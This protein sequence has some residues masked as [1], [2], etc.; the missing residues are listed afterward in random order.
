MVITNS[1]DIAN[2]LDCQA[3]VSVVLS[4]GEWDPLARYLSGE[5]AVETIAAYR[6]DWVFLGTCALHPQAGM[7][8]THCEDATLKRT[9][10]R[11]GMKAVLLTDHG[12]FDQVAPHFVAPLSAL[13]VV[14]TDV[15]A[16]WLGKTGVRVIL[17]GG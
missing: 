15:A 14:V 8:A 6:A 5:H 17:A 4:G 12:K 1:L 11:S 3:G 7:T 2:L 10:L 16:D 9:M 13:H